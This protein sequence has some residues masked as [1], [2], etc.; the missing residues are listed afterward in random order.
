V[1]QVNVHEAKTHL[2]RYL[3]RVA[4]GEEIVIARDGRPVARLVPFH[5][6]KGARLIGRGKGDFEMRDDFDDPLPAK[7][8]KSFGG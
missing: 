5:A 7:V 6:P 4:R 2:S 8:L 1:T 3:Q